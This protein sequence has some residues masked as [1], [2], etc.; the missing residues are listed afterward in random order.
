M[1]KTAKK[2]VAKA[3]T[4]MS[5]TVADKTVKSLRKNYVVTSPSGSQ[6]ILEN[7][8]LTNQQ[9][10]EIALPILRREDDSN[11]FGRKDLSAKQVPVFN[12]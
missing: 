3:A 4:K 11:S 8:G 9:A 1:A 2:I 7:K 10:R 5:V 12:V 6:V